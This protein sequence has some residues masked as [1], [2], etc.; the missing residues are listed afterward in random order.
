M[1]NDVRIIKFETLI[2]D[3]NEAANRTGGIFG[4]IGAEMAIS[5]MGQ[6]KRINNSCLALI[7]DYHKLNDYGK[8]IM[9]QS[10][11]YITD[12]NTKYGNVSSFEGIESKIKAAKELI[13]CCRMEENRKEAYKF[14]FWAMMV[15][16]VDKTDKDEHLSLICDFARMLKITDDE[17]V[18]MLQ[19]IK[20]IYHEEEPGFE[21]K[22][23]TVPSYFTRVLSLY[24]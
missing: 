1:S 21:F 17:M 8:T 7:Y 2:K 11:L 18:D 6:T 13:R 4:R 14:L 22:S 3:I 20:V 10:S 24:V 16:S 9:E 15:L 5:V 12:W 23:G 19:V